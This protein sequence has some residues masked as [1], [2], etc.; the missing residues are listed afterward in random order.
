MRGVRGMMRSSS[1][2]EKGVTVVLGR[3]RDFRVE[4]CSFVR[5]CGDKMRWCGRKGVKGTSGPWGKG[6]RGDRQ[7]GVVKEG[8]VMHGARNVVRFGW[9]GDCGRGEACSRK[10]TGNLPVEHGAGVDVIR[11]WS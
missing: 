7:R 11:L 6:T 1:V 9:A 4:A 8:G 5:C 10:E 3:E 2:I